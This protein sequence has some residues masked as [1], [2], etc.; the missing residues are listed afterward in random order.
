MKDIKTK[1][2]SRSPKI[3]TKSSRLPKELVKKSILKTKEKSM[4]GAGILEDSKENQTAIGYAGEKVEA[5]SERA[6]KAAGKE[7]I[8]VSYAVGRKTMQKTY[9]RL[10]KKKVE[11]TSKDRNGTDTSDKNPAD[12]HARTNVAGSRENLPEKEK[13][14]VR[15]TERKRGKG[16]KSREALS[17]KT[18]NAAIRQEEQPAIRTKESV[19]RTVKTKGGHGA[20]PLKE[21]SLQ[22][23]KQ[24]FIKRSPRIIKTSAALR[25][26]EGIAVPAGKKIQMTKLAQQKTVASIQKSAARVQNSAK[27]TV[28][29]KRFVQAAARTVRSAITALAAGSGAMFLVLIIIV[30]V[31]GGAFSYSA[32]QSSASLSSE[33]LSYTATIQKYA[34]QYGIPEF[35][36]VIQAIM[37]QESGGRGTDPMQSSEC[38]YNIRYPN[39]PGAIQEPEYSIQVG[40][41]YYADCLRE[42]GYDSPQDMDKLKLSLQGYNYGNGYITWALHN[43]GGYSEANALLFS[44]QQAAAHGWFSYGDPEYVAHVLRYYSGGN[45]FESLFGNGQIVSVALSQLGNEGGQKFWSWYGF[46]SYVN[47]CACF[48]SWCGDQSG[49]IEKGVM[50]KFSLCSDGMIWFQNQGKWKG[51]GSTPASGSIIFFDWNLDGTSDHVGIVEKCENGRVYTVEGNSGNAVNQRNYDI[52]YSCIM[53]YGVVGA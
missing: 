28:R 38:P 44:Q 37:M 34:N 3:L 33:V 21:E 32:S 47:W 41:Q 10:Q 4:E 2:H 9:E 49:L 19:R 14:K 31:V 22:A 20:V 1:E 51:A 13:E 15:A 53:G 43:Y 16:S 29:F 40:I 23:S 30:G 48:V 52:N 7:S 46:D 8:N 17:P 36:S 45:P 42:A 50:P 35:V 18:S 27:A 6:A 25:Q 12:D 11:K 39:S 5:V 24:F 26:G